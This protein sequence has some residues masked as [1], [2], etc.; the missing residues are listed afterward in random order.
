MQDLI[1]A[2]DLTEAILSRQMIPK[3]CELARSFWLLFLTLGPPSFSTLEFL[4]A[5]SFWRSC[6]Y[7][8][9]NAVSLYFQLSFCFWKYSFLA[10]FCHLW[11]VNYIT[12]PSPMIL[13]FLEEGLR[14]RSHMEQRIALS[15]LYLISSESLDKLLYTEGKLPKITFS[16]ECIKMD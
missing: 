13:G 2:F 6:D 4:S 8:A 11:H 1:A 15:S 5:L 14:C 16:P 10:V 3:M 7:T 9:T 12:H